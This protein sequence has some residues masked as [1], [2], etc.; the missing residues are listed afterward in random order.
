[1]ANK[2]YVSQ[3]TIDGITYD[4]KD[5]EARQ[6]ISDIQAYSDYLGVTTTALTDGA[7]TNPITIN[8]E[9]VTAKKGNIVNYGSKEFIWNGAATN[10]AWQE[11][12]DLS[13]LGE[14]A[15]LNKSDVSVDTTS[16]TVNS[17][18]A[19]GTL[20]SFSSTN[21]TVNS[22]EAVGTLP[23]F[24]ST[25]ATVNSI[26]AVGTLPSFSS[27]NATVNSIE[28]VGTLPTMTVEN[29]VLIF[30]PG[31][32]PTKGADT[33]VLATATFDAGT[34]P[35]KGSDTTVLATATF[36]A[37]TLPTKGSD[38]TVLATATFDAGTLPTKG[39]DTTVLATA[40]I[41]YTE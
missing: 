37:G 26:E 24:S 36:D 19:V 27:T 5:G 38:T 4:L 33:T 28:S 12:G 39:A 13:A 7:T 35:T 1:M 9:S 21:A 16:T 40:T 2:I 30:N 31:T 10:P 6:L 11:F 17:I 15:F 23:S 8:G 18:E 41:A 20:P 34:L 22:I 25:N 29:E 32:L 14:L 3:I